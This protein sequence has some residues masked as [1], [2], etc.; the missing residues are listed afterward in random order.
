MTMGGPRVLIVMPDDWP[1][2]LLR[3]KLRDRGY[4]A[5]AAPS[6]ADALVYPVIDPEAGP[7]R[8]LVLDQAALDPVDLDRFARRHEGVR[9]LLLALA[10][11]EAPPGPWSAV[12]R[13][14]DLGGEVP[15][16]IEELVPLTP[17]V[18]RPHPD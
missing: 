4:N 12:I 18:H 16:A 7:L 1:R 2:A 6:L 3:T 14:P 5:V 17:A 11:G 8:L 10:G 15:R 9:I 13:R